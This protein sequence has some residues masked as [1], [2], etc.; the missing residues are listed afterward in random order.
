MKTHPIPV[1]DAH[2]DWIDLFESSWR[3]AAA[4][5]EQPAFP[6]WEPQMCC[7]PGTGIIWLWDSCFMTF[8][9][10]YGNGTVPVMNNLDNLYR[11]QREDGFIGMAYEF[12][13]EALAYGERVNPPLPAWAELSYWR[14][15]GDDARARNVLPRLVRFFDWIKA[16]RRRKTGLYWF[17]DSGSTGMD[18]SP[19]SGYFSEHLN[20]SDICH[21]DLAAQQAL[22]AECIATLARH[23]GEITLADRF[24]EEHREIV[25]LLNRFH[26]DAKTGF[27][28]DVFNRD[29]PT[30][31]HN[32]V[33]HKTVASFWPLLA[34]CC[35]PEQKEGLL[36]HLLNPEEFWTKHAVASLSKDDPNFDPAGAYWL[37]GVWAPANY[38]IAKALK[39]QGHPELA[40]KLAVQHLEAMSSV[41]RSSQYSGIWEC[42]APESFLPATK[43]PWMDVAGGTPFALTPE[44]VVEAN[45]VGWSGLGPIAMLIEDV[46]GFDFDAPRNRITWDIRTSGRHGIENLLFNGGRVTLICSGLPDAE[47]EFSVTLTTDNE[48]ALSVLV[49]GVSKR[50]IV[51][52]PGTHSLKINL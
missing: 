33:N 15:S 42:Y 26:W 40:R 1:C 48:V 11:L 13:S 17:E 2:S 35:S 14:F 24:V 36:R 7:M 25:N 10:R 19:R 50:E 47:G 37:G 5:V 28:Y 27:Y 22:A 30:D 23:L 9:A 49:Q 43:K 46:F 20:G 32:F 6:G 29:T 44:T 4:N 31:R 41:Y 3:I 21:V 39:R 45:F 51:A 18:N 16:N 52:K 12:E 8:F 34:G 38:M